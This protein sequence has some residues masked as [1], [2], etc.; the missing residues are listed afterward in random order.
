MRRVEYFE[1]RE[2]IV[3]SGWGAAKTIA[4]NLLEGMYQVAI[5]RQRKPYSLGYEYLIDFI[6][7]EYDGAEFEVTG[8]YNEDD[9]IDGSIL[10][11]YKQKIGS[12][13]WD[14]AEKMAEALVDNDY[15][16]YIWTDG[17]TFGGTMPKNYTI[18]FVHEDDP[19]HEIRLV[20]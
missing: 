18:H 19:D 1:K 16:I 7:P 11:S 9:L 17:E 8:D 14:G 13:D 10:L 4:F 2:S 5:I 12:V 20:E 15:H 6:H 3:V